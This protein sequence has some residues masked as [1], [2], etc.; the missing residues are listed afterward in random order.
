VV[1]TRA[2][3]PD[4]IASRMTGPIFKNSVSWDV[5]QCGS[6]KSRRFGGT[7]RL[8][9]QGVNNHGT[10]TALAVTV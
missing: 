7:Y 9:H 2:A 1:A 8:H 5:T 10:V 3:S 4:A 6:C